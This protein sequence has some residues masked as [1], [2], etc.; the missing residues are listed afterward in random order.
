MKGALLWPS[1]LLA[2]SVD[3]LNLLGLRQVLVP[4]EDDPALGDEEGEVLDR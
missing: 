2:E 3:E 4:E 1:R